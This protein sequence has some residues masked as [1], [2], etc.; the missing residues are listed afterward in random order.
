MQIVH[1]VRFTDDEVSLLFDI[2]RK[3]GQTEESTAYDNAEKTA[4]VAEQSAKFAMLL[5]KYAEE[6]FNF[7]VKIGYS[8]ANLKDTEMYS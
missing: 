4:I 2:A 1:S 6:A 5:G 7:G 8:K 3:V